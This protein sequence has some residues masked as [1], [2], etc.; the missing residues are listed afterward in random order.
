MTKPFELPELVAACPGGAPAGDGGDEPG[1]TI[2]LG[3]L[4][5][6]PA[7]FQARRGGLDL[8][9]TATEF[10]LLHELALPD[11][12]FTRDQLL[13]RVWGYGHLGDS[14]L[15]DVAVQ[16]VRAK[17]GGDRIQTVRG[18]GYRLD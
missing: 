16:R 17:I 8:G 13:E 11:Q 12:V 3:D 10:R 5:I 2:A 4:E 18:V 7:A 9:L 15:V 14:R 6:D 1:G